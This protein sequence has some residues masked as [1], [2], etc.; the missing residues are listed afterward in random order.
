VEETWAEGIREELGGQ[1]VIMWVVRGSSVHKFGHYMD[2]VI[3][4]TLLDYPESRFVLVGDD[5]SKFFVAGWEEED[6]VKSTVG[7]WTIRET[8]AFAQVCDCVVGPETGVLNAVG[9]CSPILQVIIW[10]S[11]GI[12]R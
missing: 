10:Q 12:M 6:R 11:I 3:A 5:T 8:L 1:K 7:D 4:K 2:Q 9:V